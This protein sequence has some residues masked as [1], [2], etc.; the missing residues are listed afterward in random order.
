MAPKI[1]P[2]PYRKVHRL[3]RAH[4][5]SAVRQKGSHVFYKHPDGRGTTAVHHARD[6]PSELVAKILREAGIDP[7]ELR[8]KA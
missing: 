6:I 4:G 5:F 2:L 7:D 1:P 8:R 3:L